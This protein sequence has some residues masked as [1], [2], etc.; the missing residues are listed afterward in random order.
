[1]KVLI[2]DDD[3]TVRALV[4][5]VAASLEW[6][7]VA[8]R[9]G[10]EAWQLFGEHRFPLTVL[11]IEMP[12]M[13]GLELCRR[14]RAADPNRETFILVFTGRDSHEDLGAVLDAG[15]DD[16]IAKPTAPNS[17]RARLVIAQE[18]MAHEARRRAAEDA[19]S[20]ARWLA[21]IGETTIALQHEIN[22]PLSALLG[23]V[24]LM[25]LDQRETGD[26]NEHLRVIHEQTM[27]VADVVKRL[28]KLRDP[29]SV[30]YVAGARMIDLSKP[31]EEP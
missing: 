16:Y 3:E 11:D 20:R 5:S 26:T 28:G 15:A 31:R 6:E 24:E 13:D 14:I 9:D 27:R 19:L 8:A 21:G 12:G 1:M 25:M 22:N 10:D 29:Q 23:H 17:L 7:T 30:E 18:R 4:R 2:A